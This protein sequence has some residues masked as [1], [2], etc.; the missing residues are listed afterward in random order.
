MGMSGL[1]SPLARAYGSGA[2]NRRSGSPA[3]SLFAPLRQK[4]ALDAETFGKLIVFAWASRHGR[5]DFP[6]SETWAK[7]LLPHRGELPG[8]ARDVLHAETRA[9]GAATIAEY[10]DYMAAAQ[11]AGLVRRYNPAYIRCHVE[12][13]QLEACDRLNDYRE[14]YGTV[15]HWLEKRVER[16]SQG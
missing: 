9:L 14:K 7:E 4:A 2:R 12:V 8:D 5:S 16:L 1:N 15:I 10:S 3:N 13:G 11:D 6:D